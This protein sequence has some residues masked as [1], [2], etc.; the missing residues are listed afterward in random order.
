MPKGEALSTQTLENLLA[1]Y[2]CER[3]ASARYIAFAVQADKESFHGVASLFRAIAHSEQVHA[4]NHARVLRNFGADLDLKVLP[5]RVKTTSENLS[6]ALRGEQVERDQ[7]YPEYAD[8]ARA[9]HC[10]DAVTSFEIAS[11][12][13]EAHAL[14]FAAALDG[15]DDYRDRSEYYVCARCGWVTTGKNFKRCVLCNNLRERFDKVE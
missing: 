2:N 12:A 14:M 7:M 1:A 9:E 8:Q 4:T 5:L 15:L 6:T 3:N 10:D 11:D 13:E